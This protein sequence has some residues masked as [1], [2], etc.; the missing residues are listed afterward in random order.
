M[1][2]FISILCLCNHLLNIDPLLKIQSVLNTIRELYHAEVFSQKSGGL[3][4]QQLLDEDNRNH[5][6]ENS[7]LTQKNSELEKEIK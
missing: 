2:I 1:I 6:L 3:I 5:Q 4:I 7:L